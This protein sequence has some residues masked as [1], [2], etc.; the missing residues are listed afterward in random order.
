[1]SEREIILET[2]D[3]KKH[4][5]EVKAVDGVSFKIRAGEVVALIGPNGAGKTTFVNIVT[6]YYNPDGGKI[7]Y[8]G[9][10][11]TKAS[12]IKKIKMGI[13]RSFQLVNLYDDLTVLDN[14]RI[15][16]LS[17]MGK[18]SIFWKTV[19]HFNEI[20]KESYEILSTFGLA[21][22]APVPAKDLPQGERKILDVAIAFALKPKVLLLDEPTSGVSSKDKH[23]IMNKIIPAVRNEKIATMIIE[24]D[25]DIVF[26]YSDR[27]VVMYE[28][29]ILAE[30][31]PEEIKQSKEVQEKLLGVGVS[32]AG[33]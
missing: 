4:F 18:T 12:R 33:S 8:M 28:G 31:T 14:I 17:R 21:E 29:K 11:V 13:A 7:Y 15:A 30:G 6:G 19:E 1:L 25:M 27:V 26:G 5:G 2:I 16:V 3:M 23:A 24:H 20:K 22:K 10:D 9:R 32:A